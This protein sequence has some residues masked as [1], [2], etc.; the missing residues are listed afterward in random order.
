MN[1]REFITLLGGAAAVWPLAAKAQQPER[2]R[3]IA[4]LMLTADDADGQARITAL[5]EGLE[6]LGWTEGRNLRIDTRWAAGDADRM[7]TYVTESVQA[8]PDLILANGSPA[9]A[10]PRQE[11]RSIPIVFAA[12]IDPLGQGFVAN[13]ARPRS[14]ITG[15]TNME[16]TVLGKMLE[17]LKGMAPNITRAAAL[18]NPATGFYVP[19]YLRLFEA[20]SPS[21]GIEL[22]T[23]PVHDVSEIE[24]TVAKLGREPGGGLIVRDNRP[25]CRWGRFALASTRDGLGQQ[26]SRGDRGSRPCRCSGGSRRH[27]EHS[28]DRDRPGE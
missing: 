15:F 10:A 1:R 21:L 12:V 22:A 17:L 9:V 16:F 20:S 25:S 26:S 7:R 3:R 28:C 5:R 24:D 27:D 18:F 2:M 23:A 14:N 19:G 13:L 4:I 11:T 6:K 8:N